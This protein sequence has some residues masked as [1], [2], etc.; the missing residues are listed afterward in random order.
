MSKLYRDAYV[1]EVVGWAKQIDLPFRLQKILDD[2]QSSDN[3]KSLAR[4]GLA[5]ITETQIKFYNAEKVIEMANLAFNV[6]IITE[7]EKNDLID[8][9]EFD[10]I[11]EKWYALGEIWLSRIEEVE[12]YDLNIST[13]ERRINEIGPN[14]TWGEYIQYRGA[15]LKSIYAMDGVPQETIDRI[16]DLLEL[17]HLRTNLRAAKGERRKAA[18]YRDSI[19]QSIPPEIRAD[20]LA[21]A[22]KRRYLKKRENEGI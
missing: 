22:R 21:E 16:V 18:S 17:D 20:V 5:F 1:G 19:E 8:I 14:L 4:I 15:D 10:P 2:P 6:G 3:V 7:N 11:E 13:L 9:I 12:N